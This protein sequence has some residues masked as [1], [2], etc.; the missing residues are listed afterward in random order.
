MAKPVTGTAGDDVL[1]AT[2]VAEHFA[3]GA[4]SD[5]VS[6]I[7]AG[8]GIIASLSDPGA[9]TGWAA[10]DTYSSIENLV[11]TGFNDTLVGNAGANKL[12]GGPGADHLVG[13]GGFDFAV[14]GQSPHGVTVSLAGPPAH[15][16]GQ[17]HG[18]TFVGIEG[19]V[20]SAYN[21]HLV[22]DGGTNVLVGGAGADQLYGGRGIDVAGYFNASQGVTAN[23]SGSGPANT[24]DAAGDVYHSI[25]GLGG[26]NF[27]DRL[28]GNGGANG[29]NGNGGNDVLTGGGGDDALDG[30]LGHDTLI[31]GAGA[32]IFIFESKLVAANA[33]VIRDFSE[34]QH[35]HIELSPHPFGHLGLGALQDVHFV[36]DADGT[37]HTRAQHIVYD[38]TNGALF[39]D[40]DGSGHQAAVHFATLA[41]HPALVAADFLVA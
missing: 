35:D 22:G 29:L 5:W 34:A 40:P 20:G 8:S 4:G 25:E 1:I 38:T 7:H 11:G 9:N 24:G 31:G 13:G 15:N 27:A 36:A 23:L 3:G 10:G 37:A 33:D 18:D 26:S 12:A 2:A 19:L 32:D 28:I 30:G 41:G 14:Y 21:D 39:Y 16:T 6:Y 17:A